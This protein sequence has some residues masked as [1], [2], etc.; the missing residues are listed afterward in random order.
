M[1]IQEKNAI[2][3]QCQVIVQ[4]GRIGEKSDCNIKNCKRPDKYLIYIGENPRLS[5]LYASC[6]EKHLAF[7]IKKAI[8][9]S[10]K[11]AATMLRRARRDEIKKAKEILN[12]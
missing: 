1:T 6:C 7:T 3:K 11:E 2:Y 10:R 12:Q 9:E 5:T 8:E 4:K